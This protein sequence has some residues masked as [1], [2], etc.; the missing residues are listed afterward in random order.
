[1]SH[2]PSAP[3]YEVQDDT[4]LLNEPLSANRKKV[5]VG[6]ALLLAAGTG[7]FAVSRSQGMSMYG[8]SARSDVV[9][10]TD[11]NELGDDVYDDA[12]RSE[13]ISPKMS[14]P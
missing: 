4:V 9:Q 10:V 13:A 7:A 14:G 6:G 2:Q 3:R 1:M 12:G 5:L 8:K 11:L